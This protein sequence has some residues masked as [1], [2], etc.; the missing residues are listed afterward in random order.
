VPRE[1]W[2]NYHK[3]VR[4]YLH[5]CHKYHHP[6]ADAKSLPLFIGKLASK[7]QTAAQQT[8]AQC[9][10][11]YYAVFLSPEVQSSRDDDAVAPTAPKDS[12]DDL[13]AR[14]Q[15][16]VS[17]PSPR[18]EEQ[19]QVLVQTNGAREQTNAAWREAEAK[20]KDEIMRV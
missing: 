13:A 18:R 14:T 19:A 10:V 11:E 17:R 1:Q 3:W 5:F 16:S 15:A 12:D 7:S 2:R 20:L 6:P 4:F 8:Q 9:A